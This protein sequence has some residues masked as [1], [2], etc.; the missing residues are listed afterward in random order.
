MLC[1]FVRRF[2]PS[3]GAVLAILF[4]LCT[5]TA[6]GIS[7][8]GDD[9]GGAYSP[10]RHDRF[11][12]GSDKDFVGAALDLSGVART[13]RPPG[14]TREGQYFNWVTMVSDSHFVSGHA[15]PYLNAEVTFYK[16]D[17][18]DLTDPNNE[19]WVGKVVNRTVLPSVSG[20]STGQLVGNSG[21]SPTPP[22]WV[23]RYPLIK[24][25]ELTNYLIYSEV[26][27]ELYVVGKDHKPNLTSGYAVNVV[28]VG[29]NTIDRIS[30]N[31]IH[32]SAD[33]IDFPEDETILASGDSDAPSFT[34][35]PT[36]GSV[37]TGIHWTA[38][39]GDASISTFV[40]DIVA[41]IEADGEKVNVVTDLLGDINGDFVTD[42]DD[43][44]ILLSRYGL[45]RDYNYTEGDIDLN[46]IVNGADL[47]LL[48]R[49]LGNE[50][51]LPQINAIP[52]PSALLLA[53]IGFGACWPL[54]K[55]NRS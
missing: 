11:Y 38:I 54:L 43:L 32:F 4:C 12:E 24:R 27:P 28:R 51:K 48:L 45:I 1:V 16:K 20:L 31:Q 53:W 23:R 49:N 40:D 35:L 26:D 17:S 37:L 33:K 18:L 34:L 3:V 8:L 7:I 15:L 52:E 14:A 41:E 46:G 30:G 13:L 5:S 10:Q 21:Y 44:G 29:R 19:A 9:N 39:G 6:Y 42:A 47:V 25:P 2:C 55:R 22:S 36:I 50:M